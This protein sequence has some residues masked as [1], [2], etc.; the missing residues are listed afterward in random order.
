MTIF[1]WLL[2]GGYAVGGIADAVTFVC[3]AVS[4]PFND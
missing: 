1:L 4:P 2:L 3:N